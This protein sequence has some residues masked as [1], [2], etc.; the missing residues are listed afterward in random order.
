MKTITFLPLAMISLIS[1]LLAQSASATCTSEEQNRANSLYRQ[2]FLTQSYS[3]QIKFLDASLASCYSSE[4]KANKYL[5]QGDYSYD[6]GNYQ[7]AKKYYNLIMQEVDSIANPKTK[8]KY[9]L[10]YYKSMQEVFEQLGEKSLATTMAHKY[11]LINSSQKDQTI[12]K[13]YVDAETIYQQLA[14]SSKEKEQ[15]LRGI[16]V[17]EKK[18]NLSINFDYD[19]SVMSQQGKKQSK[20]LGAACEKILQKNADSKIE[21]IGYT[22]TDGSANYNFSLSIRRAKAIKVFLKNRYNI[23]S[24]QLSYSGQGERSPICSH[25][26]YRESQG[27]YECKESEDKV[28]SR[29]VEVRF[30]L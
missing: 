2:S 27:E 30:K 14:P 17:E 5:L 20:A 4:V 23:P 16:G 18:I 15:S 26:Q 29:R 10:L 28:A 12:H 13:T 8:Q 25:N 24:S 11:T 6:N 9:Q 21:I 19:S 3:Q 7:Q 1:M 22:D